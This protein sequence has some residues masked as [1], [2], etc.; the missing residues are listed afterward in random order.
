MAEDRPV[1]LIYDDGRGRFGPLTDR[2]APFDFRL[3]P[4]TNR[5]RIET[6]LNQRAAGLYVAPRLVAVKR[7]DETD[8]WVNQAP[9]AG[10]ACLLVNSRWTGG[11]PLD[12][13]RVRNLKP[14]QALVQADGQLIAAHLPADD[15][16][17]FVASGFSGL[18]DAIEIT[19]P[20]HDVLISRPWH[21]LDQLEA[22]LAHDL[23]HWPGP[24]V[25]P[26]ASVHPT[27]VLDESRGSVLIG[28]GATIG[29]L[30]VLEGPCCI[31]SRSVVQSHAL[32]R[33][34]SV[35]GEVCKVAGEISFSLIHSYTN[36]AHAG[37]LGHAIVG[38]WVNL[39]ADT[40]VSNLKNTYGEVRMQLEPDTAPEGSHRQSLGPVLGDFVRTAIGTKIPTGACIGTACMIATG[41]FAPKYAAP[42][43]FYTDRGREPYDADKL[44][45][46]VRAMMAR[47][48]MA[49]STAQETLLRQCLST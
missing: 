28:K 7:D 20:E 19:R 34:H 35:I 47:R 4:M 43:G 13:E 21:L 18:P 6:A 46:T 10:S 37:Y 23:R 11:P 40:T 48:D 8:A 42:G 45:G 22:T 1:L 25:A 24:R 41:G 17:R 31:G 27:A 5:V 49:L 16:A 2:R 33:P 32:I 26:D 3:G 38:E 9:P 15:A 44:I 12:P 36:K 29:A 39:G 14:R 30:A